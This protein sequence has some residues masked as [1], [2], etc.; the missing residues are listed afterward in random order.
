[1]VQEL[2]TF[3]RAALLGSAATLLAGFSLGTGAYAQDAS[4]DDEVSI[5]EVVVTGSRI[6]RDANLAGS[7]PVATTSSE[8]FRLSGQAN[9]ADVLQDQPALLTSVTSD[10]SLDSPFTS[11]FNGTTAVGQSVLQLRALGPERTLVLVNGRRHVSGVSGTQSVDIGSIPPALIERVET[12]TGGASSVYGADAVTGVVNFVLKDDFEGL[13]VDVQGSISEKGDSERFRV[14]T[15]YGQSFADGRGNFAVAVDYTR[16]EGIRARDRAHTRNS[17]IGSTGF[18]NPA[19]RFQRGDISAGNTPNLARFFSPNNGLFPSGFRIPTQADFIA[20]YEATFGETPTLT[21]AETA[22]FTRGASAPPLAVLGQLAFSITSSYGTIAPADFSSPDI[23]LNNNGNPDCLDSFLGYNSSFDFAGSFGFAGGCWINDPAGLRPVRDGLVVG[24]FNHFGGDGLLVADELNFILPDDEKYS[25]N[26]TGNYELTDNVRVF[27]EAK[28]VRQ[29]T[30]FG[31]DE[32]IF[33]DL[34]TIRPDNPFIPGALQGIA[35]DAGGLFMTID[36]ILGFNQDENQR[37][38]YRFVGGFDGEFAN[39]WNFE[40]SLNYGKFKQKTIDR[41]AILMDRFFAAID[42]TTDGNGDPICRS[43]IDDT[44]PATTPFGLPTGDPGFFTFNPGDGSCVPLNLFGIASGNVDPAAIDFISRTIVSD[45]EQEQFV[46]SGF[47]AGDTADWFN[48]PGGPVAFVIGAEYRDEKSTNEF[49]PLALGICPVTTPDCPAGRRLVDLVD[50]DGTPLFSQQSLVNAPNNYDS[51]AVVNN[52][53]GSFDVYELFAEISLP[54]LEGEA[55]AEELRIDASARYSDYST[56]G[57]AFVWNAGL[58]WAPVPDI[59][60]R[61]SF[62]RSIRAPNINELFSPDVAGFFRPVDPCSQVQIDALAAA[63]DARAPIREANC[64]ADGL[65]EGFED[66]LSARFTGAISGN[67]DLIEETA[68]TF[69]LGAI[70]EP[71]FLPGFS[72]TVDYWD[73]E[74]EDAIALV[75]A[76]DIVDNCYDSTDFPNNQFCPLF[77]RNPDTSSAQFGGFTFLRQTQVNFGKLEAAGIDFSARYAFDLG[78][79]GFNIMVAGSWFDKINRFFDPADPTLV[80]P[81]LGEIGR[82]EWAGSVNARWSFRDFQVGW[83]MR[84]Q[85]EQTYSGIEV[86]TA[87]QLYGEGNGFTSDSFIHDI[88]ASYTLNENVV[89]YGGVNN[90][91][92][93]RPFFTEFALPTSVRGRS[94]F[95]GVNAS[96]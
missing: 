93:R 28:Y 60:F 20:D 6:R 50:T 70:F 41:A 36:P 47:I 49:D 5:E 42:V 88:N 32:A 38:T 16:A 85:D 40:L 51:G 37:E 34:L 43:D 48:L 23:D 39:G 29:D 44:P 62:S 4:A 14:S 13:D 78:E 3:R 19:L 54:L 57:T 74:I 31:G 69:T 87:D 77:E 81:E 90:V 30:T 15:L 63:G 64:R 72:L 58:V 22:L 59:S 65:P 56:V 89:I 84:Y 71:N 9:I 27:G 67:P 1:M 66:P 96:F 95:L 79:H 86:E 73:I 53:S 82:P 8:D 25:I 2:K 24:D 75:A 46:I 35:N 11:G 7:A 45:F 91:G 76:Q 68:D 10:N 26:F 33:T 18:P 94:F 17:A 21:S 55:F 83:E 80:D 92:N 52:A 61:G 12:L